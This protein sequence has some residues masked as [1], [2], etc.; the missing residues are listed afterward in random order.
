MT[1]RPAFRYWLCALALC[2]VAVGLCIVYVDRPLAEFLDA[3]VRHAELWVWLNRAL[4]P[5]PLVVVAL[6]FLLGCGI[7]LISGRQL[8]PWAES[9]ILFSWSVMW[10]VAAEIICKRIFGRGWP[11]PTFVRDHLY[12]FH[13]LHGQTYWD[14]FPSGTA[15]ISLAMLSVLWILRPRWRAAGLVIVVLLWTVVI[16]GNYHWLSDMIAA[17]FLGVTVGW[18]TVRLLHPFITRTGEH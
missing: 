2:A 10:A 4:R 12:G 14:S 8:S 6:F 5:F 18:S 3:H 17:G 15:M 7:W 13:F 9:P 11:D 16:L 1:P